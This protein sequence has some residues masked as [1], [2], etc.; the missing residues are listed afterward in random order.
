MAPIQPDDT[1]KFSDF[2]LVYVKN[3]E[4]AENIYPNPQ[5]YSN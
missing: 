3:L 4:V 1:T 5:T 2:D